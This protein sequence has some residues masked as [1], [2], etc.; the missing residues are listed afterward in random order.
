MIILSFFLLLYFFCSSNF[1]ISAV[2]ENSHSLKPLFYKFAGTWGNHEGSLLLFIMIVGIYGLLFSRYYNDDSK[3]KSWVIFFQN[4]IFLIFLIFLITT[5]NPFDLIVPTPI[6]GL[7]L[8]PILQDPLLVIHPPFLY[9]GY[10]GFSLTL[11]LVLS[12]MC[13]A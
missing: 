4:N 3:F 6:E 9:L 2:Y 8:N 13:R 12:G 7:G 10:V 5:S 1:N 11:S